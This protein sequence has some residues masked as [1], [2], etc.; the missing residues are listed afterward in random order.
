MQ[1]QEIDKHLD[2]L[3]LQF[4]KSRLLRFFRQGNRADGVFL[5]DYFR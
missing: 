3:D 4:G 1:A 5:L 2:R